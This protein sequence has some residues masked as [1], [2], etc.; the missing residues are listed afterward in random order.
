MKMEKDAFRECLSRASLEFAQQ[1]ADRIAAEE[2]ELEL[3]AEMERD[4]ELASL[5]ALQMGLL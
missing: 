1:A 5:V 3:E 2:E 4:S